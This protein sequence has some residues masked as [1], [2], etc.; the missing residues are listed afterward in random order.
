VT[1][2]ELI[3]DS[4][5]YATAIKS[6]ESGALVF[7]AVNYGWNGYTSLQGAAQ[8]SS[9][10]DTILNFQASFLKAMHNADSAAGR[11]LVD[12]LD[13]HW[14][15]EA[16][17]SNGVRITDND[18]TA[19]TVA[20]RVQ[21]PRSLWDP[22]YT[23]NTDP[24]K[25]E[26][27]WITHDSLPFQPAQTPAQFKTTAIQLLPREMALVNEYDPG[28]KLSISEYNYGGA[29]H[30]SGGIAEADALGIFGQQGLFSA[31]EWP[32][33]SSEPFIAGGMNMFRNYDGA[34]STFGDTSIAATT[35]DASLSS[36]YA[37]VDSAH[38]G[39]LTLVAINKSGSSLDS[40]I[41][42]KK[43]LPQ[44]SAS[45]Y[46]LTSASATPQS[47]G[48]ISI[49]DPSNITYTM[50][51]TSVSTIR[52]Q[53]VAPSVV[54][55]S[56]VYAYQ[57]SPN[58]LSFVF[59]QDVSASLSAADVTVTRAGGSSIP[60][61]LLSYDSS[62]NTATFSM[63]TPLADGDYTATIAAGGVSNAALQSMPADFTFNFF[64]LIGDAN[65]D[66]VVNALDFN[67]LASNYGKTG[68]TFANGDFNFSGSV[69]SLDFAAL[70]AHF[71]SSLPTPAPA[72]AFVALAPQYPQPAWSSGSV[73]SIQN[74]ARD[75]LDTGANAGELDRVAQH[76]S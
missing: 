18:N 75:V 50:L 65:H 58:K 48:T 71:N 38:P 7:G 39:V 25:G 27:S 1:Y 56:A 42:L 29:N 49:T 64:S 55:N 19:A 31:N 59:N 4:V 45:V 11:R 9:I 24:T 23:Y 16:K 57:T 44:G 12:V 30:I 32:L 47:A 73:G 21:A 70:A 22:S 28:M 17:G 68:V 33:Q 69:D 34:N 36:I 35:D 62:T 76:R 2:Q 5:N 67:A 54:P 8:D 51:P 15:P 74:L 3:N 46:R 20:A 13:M 72:G 41:N 66:H 14:Y 10:T 43:L 6:V 26:N 60:L 37:S 53:L 52:I 61:T 63:A 40:V